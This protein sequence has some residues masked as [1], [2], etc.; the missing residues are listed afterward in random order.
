ML[1]W[2]CPD[3]ELLGGSAAE[4][5]LTFFHGGWRTT[6]CCLLI[7]QHILVLVKAETAKHSLSLLLLHR[8]DVHGLLISPALSF[9]VGR[10]LVCGSSWRSS[11]L[12]L[13]LSIKP[14]EG[15]LVHDSEIVLDPVGSSPGW[16]QLWVGSSRAV[17]TACVKAAQVFLAR[18]CSR[19][20]QIRPAAS[21]QQ[22][23]L[24]QPK[25]TFLL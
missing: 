3:D 24:G 18:E 10:D 7:W 6:M 17:L 12:W 5:S 23:S 22:Q 20:V 8:E 25:I 4:G 11:W 2:N 14:V 13:T 19:G 16:L 9:F 15:V 1:L 21:W